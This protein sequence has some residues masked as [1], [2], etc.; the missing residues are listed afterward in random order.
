M[1]SSKKN[2]MTQ[3]DR[4]TAAYFE[5]MTEEEAVAERELER[6]ITGTCSGFVVDSTEPLECEHGISDR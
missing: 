1:K 4:D 6:A 5:N 2:Q 3:L